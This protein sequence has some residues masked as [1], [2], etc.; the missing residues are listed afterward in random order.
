MSKRNYLE[1][2]LIPLFVMA[3]SFNLLGWLWHPVYM[4]PSI[5][6]VLPIII[7]IFKNPEVIV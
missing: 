2:M 5:A 7:I 3:I 1:D 6:L 4:L